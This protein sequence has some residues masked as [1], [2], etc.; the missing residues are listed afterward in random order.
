MSDATTSG[1]LGSRIAL[2]LIVTMA[3]VGGGAIAAQ[4]ASKYVSSPIIVQEKSNWCWVAAGK[5]L[6]SYHAGS[7]PTQ[8]TAYKW[9]K[10]GST[11]PN[12]TGTLGNVYSILVT[13]GLTNP[14]TVSATSRTYADLQSDLNVYRP[15]VARWGWDSTGG[16]TGH[17]VVIRGYNTSGSTVSYMNPLLSSYQ[18]ST[19]TW[20]KAGGGH[21]WTDTLYGAAN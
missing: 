15:A 14:G 20:M 12:N 11:C 7:N 21:T 3:M 16:V 1:W 17:M 2:G 6:A 13:A 4:A 5:S 8:C 18:S 10:G 19:Y 9:A